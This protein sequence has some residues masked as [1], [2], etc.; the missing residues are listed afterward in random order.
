MFCRRRRGNCH[1][2]LRTGSIKTLLEFVTEQRKTMRRRSAREILGELVEWL[3][4][5]Q[6]AGAQDRKYVNRLGEFMKDWEP[7][8]E[9]RG[10]PEFLEYLDYFAQANG[11]LSL[12]DD[13]PGDAVQLMTV[14][15]AKGLEFPHV[16]LLRVNSNALP[17]AQ[18][19][20]AF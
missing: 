11:T 20:A 3:E 1:L 17:G 10:L 12:E 5:P 13:P 4:V 16:F 19:L 7:K 18:S 6:R 14:H 2:I 15:G 8:S 9:T